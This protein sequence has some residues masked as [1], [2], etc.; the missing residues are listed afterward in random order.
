M[1][2]K[3]GHVNDRYF[4]KIDTKLHNKQSSCIVKAHNGLALFKSFGLT[5]RFQLREKIY[6]NLIPPFDVAIEMKL[7]SEVFRFILCLFSS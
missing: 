1:S 7:N 4:W 2:K 6:S 3:S 5:R